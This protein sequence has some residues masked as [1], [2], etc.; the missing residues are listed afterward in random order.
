MKK[1]L[2][3]FFILILSAPLLVA[4]NLKRANSLFEKRA[5]VSAAELYENE[6]PKSQEIYEKLGDCYYFNA[7]MKKAELNYKI[8]VSNFE[9]TVN[10][11]YLFRYSQTLKGINSFNEADKWLQKYYAI[12]QIKNTENIATLPYFETLNANIKRPYELHKISSNTEGSDFGTAF[13]GNTIVFSST[14][15]E[16]SLYDWNNLPY[17]D[18]F[19]AEKTESGDL[20][21]IK[22]FSKAIN[23]KM[24]ESNPTFTKDGKTMYFTRNNF[25]DGKKGKDNKKITRL[26][27]YRAQLVD[28]KWINITELPFNG[29]DYSTVHPALSADEKQLYFAS[30]MPESIGSFDLFV[31]DIKSNGTFGSPKN[32]G[33]TINTEFREQFPFVSSNNTIYFASDGHF[34]LG[35]LDIFK[36][37]VSNQTFSKPVNLSDVINS[38]LDDFAFIIDE[39]K[40]TGY[41]SSN[42]TGGKGNDD[43]YY[44][45]QF[46][47]FFVQGLV[48]NKNSLELITGAKITLLN[49]KNK[50]IANTTTNNEAFY[51]LEIDKNSSYKLQA[52]AKQYVPYE[53]AFSTDSKGN[54][55]KNIQ[56][57]LELFTDTEKKIVVENNKTQIKINPIYFD[58]NKW[59]IREDAAIELDSV[60][61][62]MKKY[63]SMEIEIGT[64][65]DVRGTDEFNLYLSQQRAQSVLEYLI[66]EGIPDTNISSKG[67]GESQPIN[68]CVRDG[69]C[70][71]QEHAVNRRCE[72]VIIN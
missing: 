64:H 59:N 42:R 13:Y 47:Q 43:I 5:Y 9:K 61:S 6:D 15:N 34:G 49:N 30:D 35:G 2:I 27:I 14:R 40:E 62:I 46:Q 11:T 69:I 66:S 50:I 12:K 8:L 23:T 44:F 33:S 55:D 20:V 22:P 29:D 48:K 60:V 10:P 45:T 3:T 17:L 25:I 71:E 56:L 65:T 31:V 58:F 7:E 36:S 4:Q 41:F 26:K 19:Q 24:H 18:L 37:E 72:F 1:I 54:I 68:K 63:P 28:E 53:I 16:G 57:F 38:N 32:L 39:D 67:Y 21:N 70:T 51:S 52:T